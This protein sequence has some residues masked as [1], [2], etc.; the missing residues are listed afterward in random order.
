MSTTLFSFFIYVLFLS[1]LSKI[2]GFGLD[3]YS[4]RLEHRFNLSNQRLTGWLID[5]AKGWL[6]GL[7]LATVLCEIVYALI[8]TSPEHWWIYAWLIFI[9]MFIFF[10][11]IAPV[12]LFPLFL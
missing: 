12:V 3:F 9:G 4:F 6:L 2:L 11:Q 7:V 8:R 10:T 5:E 1:I